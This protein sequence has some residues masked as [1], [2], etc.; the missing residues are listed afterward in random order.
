MVT[1]KEKED[2]FFS[3]CLGGW[4]SVRK[5]KC[6]GKGVTLGQKLIYLKYFQNT[7]VLL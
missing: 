5:T 7:Q 3:L 2:T 6:N 1:M 4:R